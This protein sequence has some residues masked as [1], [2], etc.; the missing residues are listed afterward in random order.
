MA[1]R[2]IEAVTK[3]AKIAKFLLSNPV[4]NTTML[5]MWLR[6]ENTHCAWMLVD[7]CFEGTKD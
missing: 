4:K 2:P 6:Y 3:D 5:F 7:G 1:L